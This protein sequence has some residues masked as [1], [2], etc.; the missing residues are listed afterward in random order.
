MC[1]PIGV[2]QHQEALQ[3]LGQIFQ[4]RDEARVPAAQA[5][6]HGE[7]CPVLTNLAVVD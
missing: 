2:P 5:S 1:A 6:R 7:S 4:R 3:D